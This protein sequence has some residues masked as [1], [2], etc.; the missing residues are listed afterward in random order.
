[1]P[2]KLPETIHEPSSQPGKLLLLSRLAELPR[3]FYATLALCLFLMLKFLEFSLFEKVSLWQTIA[4][5]ALGYGF[6]MLFAIFIYDAILLRDNRRRKN[7]KPSRSSKPRGKIQSLGLADTPS[8]SVPD[9]A[10]ANRFPGDLSPTLKAFFENLQIFESLSKSSPASNPQ[11]S[12]RLQVLAAQSRRIRE[13]LEQT[14]GNLSSADSPR[15][16]PDSRVENA[17]LRQAPRTI[18]VNRLTISGR[19]LE[20]KWFE[21]LSYTLNT[22]PF[23]ACVLLPGHPLQV[24]QTLHVCDQ[25]LATQASIRWLSNSSNGGML[26]AGLRF[27]KPLPSLIHAAPLASAGG[28]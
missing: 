9:S 23:G 7:P 4:T 6:L 14:G 18:T 20:K 15:K 16:H 19:D 21:T 24:G 11:Y 17:C 2:A 8:P 26:I 22:S 12:A 5:Q 3:L 13:I 25:H 28:R 27:A 10:R 1:M